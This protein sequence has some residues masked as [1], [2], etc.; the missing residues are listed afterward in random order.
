[1]AGMT[2]FLMVF[3]RTRPLPGWRQGRQERF[4]WP[5]AVEPFGGDEFFQVA[6][7]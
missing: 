5:W 7:T 4:V 2:Q 1:M 3:L 6:V